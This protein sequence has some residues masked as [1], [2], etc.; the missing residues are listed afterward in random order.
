M[1]LS[2]IN[3][4]LLLLSFVI[5]NAA[6][7]SSMCNLL[8]CSFNDSIYTNSLHF[9][10]ETLNYFEHN[11][12]AKVNP[13]LCILLSKMILLYYMGMGMEWDGIWYGY[14]DGMG[15]DWMGWDGGMGGDG[16]GD[17]MGMGMGLVWVWVGRD[18]L[19]WAGLG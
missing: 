5:H 15:W 19:G 14:G 8:L 16:I 2:L 13:F 11:L 18:G 6:L 10:I 4:Y 9:L 3:C 17:G 12:V 7:V 1:G